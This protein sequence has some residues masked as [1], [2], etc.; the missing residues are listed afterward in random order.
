MLSENI[1]HSG[2][3][4][5]EAVFLAHKQGGAACLPKNGPGV[6]EVM[7]AYA[8]IWL[9]SLVVHHSTHVTALDQGMGLDLHK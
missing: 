1:V 8:R 5:D 4:E 7:I 6:F 2:G 3:R 9:T